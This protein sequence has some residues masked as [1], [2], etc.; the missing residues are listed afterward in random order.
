M[1]SLFQTF[2]SPEYKQIFLK[3]IIPLHP[4]EKLP[5]GKTVVTTPQSGASY[6]VF[7]SNKSIRTVVTTLQIGVANT[8]PSRLREDV[9]VVTTGLFE[10]AY[11][12]SKTSGGGFCFNG[13]RLFGNSCL[14][15]PSV[16]PKASIVFTQ[17]SQTYIIMQETTIFH[18]ITVTGDGTEN[19]CIGANNYISI[20]TVINTVEFATIMNIPLLIWVSRPEQFEVTWDL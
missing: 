1:K 6:T 4:V 5:Q 16:Y 19:I 12:T 10:V 18:I 3:Q 9:T 11:Q 13:L 14:F 8:K 2:S 7:C 20:R 15:P 17:V